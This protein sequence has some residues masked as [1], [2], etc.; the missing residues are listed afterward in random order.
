[1]RYFF[2]STTS[3]SLKSTGSK[4]PS[5]TIPSRALLVT[6]TRLPSKIRSS[7]SRNRDVILKLS[8]SQVPVFQICAFL[9]GMDDVEQ[10]SVHDPAQMK[11]HVQG[12][13][14]NIHAKG[15]RKQPRFADP[16]RDAP[17]IF[18]GDDFLVGIHTP[19][20]RRQF[21]ECNLLDIM[22]FVGPD[23]HPDLVGM[24]CFCNKL[25][26]KFDDNRLPEFDVGIVPIP[27][28]LIDMHIGEQ[29]VSNADCLGSCGFVQ[30]VLA[31]LM[32]IPLHAFPHVAQKDLPTVLQQQTTC[33]EALNGRHRVGH[34]DYGRSIPDQAK[35]S[36]KALLLETGI[37]DRQHLIYQE[38]IRLG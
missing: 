29:D 2:L 17:F 13:D 26:L 1:M 18:Q 37:P 27:S 24:G 25:V 4:T 5:R 32:E 20:G 14:G 10:R 7:F 35:D 30:V 21:L 34:E 38:D 31:D 16:N 23:P 19:I 28:F 8:N 33:T 3:W 11:V 9:S 22:A 12:T 6:R 15:L 36:L